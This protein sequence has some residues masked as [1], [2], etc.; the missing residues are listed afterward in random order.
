M[1]YA[2]VRSS[3]NYGISQLDL[4]TQH[5]LFT[6]GLESVIMFYNKLPFEKQKLNKVQ[7]LDR[8]FKP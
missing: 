8:K 1:S 6:H 5:A 2:L 4:V 3:L 7:T